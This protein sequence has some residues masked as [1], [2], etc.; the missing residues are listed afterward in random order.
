MFDG[1]R[2]REHGSVERVGA[3]VL[4]HHFLALIE[5]A[6][7][8][9]A[10]LAARRLFHQFE[11]LFEAL[12]LAFGLAMML[13]EGRSQLVGT[14]RL[15]HL[16]QRSQNLLFGVIN[17]LERIQEEVVEVFVF[18]GHGA[19]RC[20]FLGFLATLPPLNATSPTM[21]QL[22]KSACPLPRPSRR[23]TA[24]LFGPSATARSAVAQPSVVSLR[25]RR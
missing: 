14:G 1:L 12:D 7:D 22:P 25:L 18:R 11:N 13:L 21:F 20:G 4:L 23:D 24:A 16:R 6:L 5:D 9:I 2:R 3:F 19:L 10:G 8:A 17:I 15:R